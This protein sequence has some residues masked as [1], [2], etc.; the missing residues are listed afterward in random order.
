M[1]INQ[2]TMIAVI[3][4]AREM[5]DLLISFRGEIAKAVVKEP[6][7]ALMELQ[8]FAN[9]HH[10]QHE[11]IKLI[12]RLEQYYIMARHKN[13]YKRKWD[14]KKAGREVRDVVLPQ[15]F[16]RVV[17]PPQDQVK[18]LSGY[19]D[20]QVSLVTEKRDTLDTAA[21]TRETEYLLSIYDPETG[22]R[23]DGDSSIP[24]PDQLFR[25]NK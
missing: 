17:L 15:G 21:I 22:E 24:A 7:Q 25:R 9:R 12:T 23:L 5:E 18:T 2:E 8:D 14:A 3:A 6:C 16:G 10:P 4:A 11:N 19:N 13:N 20:P 1:A